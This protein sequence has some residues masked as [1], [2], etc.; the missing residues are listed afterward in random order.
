MLFVNLGHVF[1]LKFIILRED[2]ESDEKG[3]IQQF[4]YYDD[5]PLQCL[6]KG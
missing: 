1:M 6:E 2:V 5:S 3:S 4:G